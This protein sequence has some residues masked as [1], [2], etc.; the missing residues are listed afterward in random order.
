MLNDVHEPP[1]EPEYA[2]RLKGGGR[3]AP[4]A[5]KPLEHPVLPPN[6]KPVAPVELYGQSVPEHA[7]VGGIAYAVAA[8]ILVI[9]FAMVLWTWSG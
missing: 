5:G 6:G 1:L 9:V 3:A 2:E 4:H 7:F 8:G